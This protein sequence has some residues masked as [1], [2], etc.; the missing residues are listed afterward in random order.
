ME[1]GIGVMS[2]L[3]ARFAR[4]RSLL[5]MMGEDNTSRR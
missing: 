4:I 3:L 2:E 1:V 5:I